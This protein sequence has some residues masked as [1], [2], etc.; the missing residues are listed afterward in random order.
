MC[1][2]VLTITI[3]S[4]NE[5]PAY[6]ELITAS[7]IG[8]DNSSILELKNNRG[9]DFSIKS[10]KIWLGEDN[11]FKSFKTEKGWTGQFQVNGQ[12]LL[13]SS[14]DTIKPG[15]SVKFG[16][17]TDSKNPIINW[18][19]SDNNAQTIESAAIITRQSDSISQD[20]IENVTQEVSQAKRTAI[21]ENSLFRFIPEKPSVGSDFRIIGENFIPNQ[22]VDLYISNQII[23]S[24]K[25]DS[26]GKFVSTASVPDNIP[27]KRTDFT[28]VDSGGTEKTNSI[29]LTD[30]AQREMAEDVKIT[31]SHTQKSVKRGEIL[32]IKG[33]ATPDTTLTLTSLDGNGNVMNINTITTGFDGKWKFDN[34]FP[35]DLK[36]GKMSIQVTDGKTTVVRGFEIIS[37]QRI[38]ISPVQL[39]YEVGET[40]KFSG[41][42]IPNNKISLILE[43][44][45]GA[46]VF[47]KT[48]AVDSSGNILVE[49]DS[50]GGMMDGTYILYAYQGSESAISVVGIGELPQKVLIVNS[51][52]LNYNSGSPVELNIQGQ[53]NASVSLVVI[54]ESDKTRISDT[55][56][57]DDNG[58]HVYYIDSTELGTGAFVVEVRYGNSRG[59]T[60]FTIGLSTGSGPI[61]FR[62]T[63]TD[64]NLGEQ[65]LLIGKTGNSVVLNVVIYDPNGILIRS[66]ETFSDRTGIFKVD[67][68]RIPTNAET[69]DW[70]VA[71]SSGENITERNFIVEAGEGGISVR[72][73]SEENTY[74]LGDVMTINGKDAILGTTVTITI[75]DSGGTEIDQLRIQPKTTGEFYTIWVIPRD[76]VE[77][78]YQMNVTDETN[79]TSLSFIID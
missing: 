53:S 28:L 69:G 73:D 60:Q 25:I 36:L 7:S 56:D 5:Q 75:L 17:K 44:P 66:F 10:V 52:Q 9:N 23:K 61:D 11:S 16:I 41:T 62:A 64:Y 32:T 54:D 24:I 14:Q 27:T 71:I 18:K 6:G 77:G 48:M 51:I 55:I 4:I 20:E 45:L 31:I 39:S 68:F 79:S 50:T 33:D 12:V 70:K 65:V 21:N 49:I 30:V 1:I 35:I 59:D 26:N 22:I 19:A 72:L 74:N 29:R 67:N 57:L 58:N 76:I 42:A 15:Q 34:L 8:L 46:E 38:N 40:M 43:D 78:I 13:F 2:L 63:K 3:L 37:S 47:A